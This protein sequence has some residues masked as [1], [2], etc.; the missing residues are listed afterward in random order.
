[1]ADPGALRNPPI[2][3]ALV[4]LRI[5]SQLSKNGLASIDE[6]A[7]KPII[8]EL[9]TDYPISSWHRAMETRIEP[10]AGKPVDAKT[11]EIGLYGLFLKD[12]GETRIAQFRPDGFTLSQLRGYSSGDHLLHEAFR[13]WQI[14]T[15]A[16]NP[17]ATIRVAL[18]YINRLDLP[19]RQGDEFTRFLT[20]PI[21]MPPGTTQ[22]VSTF[23]CRAVAH[24]DGMT[25]AVV[26]QNLESGGEQATPFVLDIDVFRSGVFSTHAEDLL[27]LLQELRQIKNQL[28]FSFL[29][30]D[31]LEPYR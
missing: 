21:T 27:P 2:R 23:L 29:T 22:T 28:F 20:A 19:F 1:M 26:T 8:S 15:K 3:E 7:L 18:R 6:S 10:Q 25:S 31:A 5:A 24:P 13:L 17:S 11:R 14:F 30:N 12:E 16:V 4:D 9:L